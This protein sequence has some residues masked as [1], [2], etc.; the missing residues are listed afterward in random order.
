MKRANNLFP[1][2]CSLENLWLADDKARKG[3]GS[4]RGIREHSRKRRANLTALRE[5]LVNNTYKTSPYTTFKIYEP[6]EREIYRLPYYPDRILHHAVMN[7]LEPIFTAM[8]TA[9]S[10][11]CIKGRG[12]HGAYNAVKRALKDRAGTQYRLK[13]DIR[14]F[15]PNV[16]HAILKELLRRKFKDNGLLRLLDE[17]IDSAPGLPIGNYLS[18]YLANFYLTGFDHWIKEVKGVKYYFRYADDIVIFTADKATLHQLRA[19]ITEYMASQLK[20]E[21]KANYSVAPI[22]K[23]GLDFVGYVFRHTH[24]RVR[25]WIKKN[26]A[27]KLKKTRNPAVIASYNGFLKHGNCRHLKK[28]LLHGNKKVQ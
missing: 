2:I 15:Y 7:V 6:K 12:I 17:I 9:D 20:L 28:R 13:L 19:D 22:D 5:M 16:D 4:S 23:S 14:K 8:F 11:S 27:R 1:Q 21:V 25:K 10:Y 26:F 18:Q 3:K 24:I